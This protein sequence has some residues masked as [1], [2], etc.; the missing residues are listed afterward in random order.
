MKIDID[1]RVEGMCNK[2]K[3]E[4]EENRCNRCG[5]EIKEEVHSTNKNFDENKFRALAGDIDG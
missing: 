4:T 1:E 2:C 3:H 5:E